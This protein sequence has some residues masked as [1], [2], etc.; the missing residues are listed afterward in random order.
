M[1]SL[2]TNGK[3]PKVV[4]GF[5]L[6]NTYFMEFDTSNH[7]VI[8]MAYHQ[9]KLRQSSHYV[10]IRDSH[11]PAPARIYF[12]VARV[13]LRM[14]GTRYY[15]KRRVVWT[16]HS[17]PLL[18]TP[19]PPPPPPPPLI[20]MAPLDLIPI[21]PTFITLVGN[22]FDWQMQYQ[23]QELLPATEDLMSLFMKPIAQPDALHIPWP[24][25]PPSIMPAS[26]SIFPPS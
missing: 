6:E 22:N 12:G 1:R 21:D 16:T 10:T 26:S 7:R 8:E 20:N 3:I 2:S 9:R 5:M 18:P 19:P 23:P 17:S 4:W 11:L 14:P 25:T 13:H 24:S 15:V